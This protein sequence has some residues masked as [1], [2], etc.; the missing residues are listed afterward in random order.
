MNLPKQVWTLLQ[1]Q[2]D[3]SEALCRD[4]MIV[5]LGRHLDSNSASVMVDCGCGDGRFTA[6]MARAVN[7]GRAIGIDVVPDNIA[8]LEAQGIE[9]RV[10]DLDR[11]LPLEGKSADLVVASHVIE[12]VA[13]TDMLVKECYRVLCPGGHLLIATPNLAA[14]LN[15][16]FLVLGKQPTIAEVSDVALVGTWSPR[17]GGVARTGPAHRR[18]F[19]TGALTGLLEYYGFTCKEVLHSGFL[20][21]AGG[22]ARLMASMLPRYASNLIVLATKPQP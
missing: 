5:L 14:F 18:I 22:P 2:A 11:G 1:Q 21:L 9:G 7:A 12:H 6:R 16:L 17:A 19:T 3:G 8:L 4:D 10:G 15:V 13:D 20:P